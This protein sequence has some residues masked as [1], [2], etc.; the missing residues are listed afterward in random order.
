MAKRDGQTEMEKG[1]GQAQGSSW[2][3]KA[4]KTRHLFLGSLLSHCYDDNDVLESSIH[5]LKICGINVKGR[6]IAH[7]VVGRVFLG[8]A[9]QNLREPLAVMIAT[10]GKSLHSKIQSCLIIVFHDLVN[11]T[12][13]AQETHHIKN[14]VQCGLIC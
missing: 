8:M 2:T 6:R 3:C 7:V 12:F 11:P 5:L 9:F 4:V 10:L 14:G 13:I 1:N